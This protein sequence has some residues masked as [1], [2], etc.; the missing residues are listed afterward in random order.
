MSGQMRH[1]RQ[2]LIVPEETRSL[3]VLIVGAGFLGSWT[4]LTL[5]RMVNRVDIV[6]FDT[7][8]PENH[9]TQAFTSSHTARG[10][11]L[12]LMEMAGD[13]PLYGLNGRFDG[14]EHISAD[15]DIVISCVDSMATR[16]DILDAAMG[17]M[18]TFIDTRA[19]GETACVAVV[20]NKKEHDRYIAELP[21]DDEVPQVRCG[22]EGATYTGLWVASYVAA[23]VN[24]LGRGLPVPHK[25][26][27]HV[28][29]N[30]QV[31]G[32]EIETEE[33]A[34]ELVTIA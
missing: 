29:L 26:V 8:G 7:V 19:L 20:R 33:E 31:G 18:C 23:A 12:A 1:V 10:K 27:W 24:N 14:D 22:A 9:G 4:A 32:S 17:T 6:D 34:R 5:A 25:I 21:S 2:A 16:L 28:G 11:T 3:N 15:H 30:T 13:L